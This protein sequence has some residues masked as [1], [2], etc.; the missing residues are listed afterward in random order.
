MQLLKMHAN[1]KLSLIKW[2]GQLEKVVYIKGCFSA[3]VVVFK[4]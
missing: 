1:N 3:S 2:S 4:E